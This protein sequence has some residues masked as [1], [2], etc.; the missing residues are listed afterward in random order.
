MEKTTGLGMAGSLGWT[1]CIA[2]CQMSTCKEQEEVT[3]LVYSTI[4]HQGR[5][6][7]LRSIIPASDRR[8]SDKSGCLGF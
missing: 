6:I 7:L 4:Q 2:L 3:R 8:M 5:I 1:E